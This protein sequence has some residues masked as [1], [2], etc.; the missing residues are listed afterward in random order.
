[1][2]KVK[3]WLPDDEYKKAIG[4]FGMQIGA[5]LTENFDLYGMGIYIP[6]AQTEIIKLAE[7]FG[8]RIRGE[9]KPIS[10]EYVRR[11]KKKE[12]K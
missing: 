2:T 3:H 12:K 8:L 9:D 5:L 11:K 1:M 10:L 7:D 6:G 4:Q